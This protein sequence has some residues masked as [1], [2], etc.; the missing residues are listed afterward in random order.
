MKKVFSFAMV[1][2]VLVAA[3]G[4]SVGSAN[5]WSPS[6][7]NPAPQVFLNSPAFEGLGVGERVPAVTADGKNIYC[8]VKAAELVRCEFP[9]KFAGKSVTLFLSV[10]DQTLI[11]YVNVPK[12]KEK[13][14][15]I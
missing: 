7:Q 4:V 10:G 8:V 1:L 14:G 9:K 12:L 15:P 2:F 6:P 11:F 13:S 3:F 5:A